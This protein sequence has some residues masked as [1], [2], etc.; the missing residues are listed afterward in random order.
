MHIYD[1][2]FKF[3]FYCFSQ[4]RVSTSAQIERNS[5]K[6]NYNNFLKS[7]FKSDLTIDLQSTARHSTALLFLNAFFNKQRNEEIKYVH[8]KIG[9]YVLLNLI[10]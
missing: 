4:Q 5:R 6:F 9:G 7:E 1:R 2:N 10:K 8:F 3:H